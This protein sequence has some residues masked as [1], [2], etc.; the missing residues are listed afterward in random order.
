MNENIRN[1]PLEKRKEL[2]SMRLPIGTHFRVTILSLFKSSLILV[3]AKA[4]D[5]RFVSLSCDEDGYIPK[6]KFRYIVIVDFESTCDY[7]PYPQVD[8]YSSEIIEF[9]WVV[10]DT[11]TLS[12]VHEERHYVRPD[13][14]NGITRYCTK[15]TGITQDTVKD[16]KSLKE[17]VEIFNDY[18]ENKL[19]PE[20]G[21]D[22]CLL[23]DGMF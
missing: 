17:V 15:L 16:S 2:C 14:M 9:P 13:D 18:I 12:I 5:P 8:A 6:S 1:E 10:F 22:F 21:N 4:P 11:K 7:S 20:S 3:I 19:I 23:T